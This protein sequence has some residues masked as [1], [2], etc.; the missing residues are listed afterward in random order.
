V[1]TRS[2]APPIAVVTPEWLEGNLLPDAAATVSTEERAL[3]D[4]LADGAGAD[5]LLFGAGGLG[6]YTLAGLRRA[7][8]EPLAFVDNDASLH[9]RLVEGIPVLSPP[10]AADRYGNT[11]VVVVTVWSPNQGLAYPKIAAQMSALG[12]SRTVTFVPLFW[13]H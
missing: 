12:S 1:S 2:W 5:L 7:G 11:V 10:D 9:G 13:K 6:R 4:E 8:R 3:F